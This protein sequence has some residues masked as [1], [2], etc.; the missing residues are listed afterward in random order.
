M[1]VKIISYEKCNLAI[2]V[3]KKYCIINPGQMDLES[4]RKRIRELS[5]IIDKHNY[6]YYVLAE[7]TIS[8][9]EYDMLMEEL[10]ELENKFSELIDIN[11]P[12]QRVGGMVTKDFPAVRHKY[13]MLSLGN[14]YSK[15]ELQDF[16]SRIRKAIGDAFEY[17]CE[18]KYDG[19]AI[20]LVYENKNLVRAVTRGDGY[21][22]D[23]VTT[24]ARTI[25][26]IPLKLFDGA[27][28][29]NELE[30]RGEIFMPHGSF[31]QLNEARL[32]NNEAPFANPRNAAAGSLKLRESK[33]VASRN[34]DCFIYNILGENL[35]FDDHYDNLKLAKKWGFKIPEF[36]KKCDD[37]DKVF[38][39][40]SYWEK[41]RKTLDYDT[42][43]IVIKI[44]SIEQ[45]EKLGYTAKSPRWAIAYKFPAQQAYTRLLDVK[46]QVGRTGAITPV[47][48]LQ[49][50]QLSG[51]TVKRASLYNADKIKELELHLNDTVIVEKGGEIIPKI[52]GVDI[53]HRDTNAQPVTY[54]TKCSEC[55]TPLVKGEGEA[56]HYCPNQK[57]CPPQV[58]GKIEHF[59]S[60][61]AMNI[62][63][64]GQGRTEILIKNGLVKNI[65]DLY[66]LKYEQL[67]GLEKTIVNELEGT[68]KKISFREK[69]VNNILNALEKS[70]S[71]PFERV[72]YALG[73]RYVG[74]TVAKKI[75]QHFTSIDNLMN[76]SFEQL[77]E[78]PEVGKKIAYSIILFFQDK[79]NL[80]IIDRL[81]SKG[82]QFETGEK[83]KKGGL[84][85]GKVFVISGVFEKYSRQGLKSLI[86]DNGGKVTG[87]VSS[88]TDYLVAG[89]NMG[90]E[91]RKKAVELK[92]PLINESE[93]EEL[94][95]NV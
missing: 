65:A 79:D 43:G 49:P 56:L 69:T 19:V 71:V 95:S 3:S 37:L 82:L 66:D 61:K 22:G 5:G 93:F 51:T 77:L 47:A 39:Y 12:T 16:D 70:K 86:E 13:P 76:S 73:I 60:R 10:I 67:Y 87:S 92:V 32:K 7:P 48:V 80:N 8:D 89:E 1:V 31:L 88:N 84:L 41:E 6:K 52:V 34:L 46:Y 38:Q 54:A 58:L 26:S 64:L 20:G 90:P 30:V 4:A 44:N 42:D 21:Q 35:P 72:L 25:K 74:E 23:D 91:K 27:K 2:I 40:I 81:K 85:N 68:S 57:D 28:V 15:K 55:N 53:K 29:P 78:V 59:I 17:V 14:T 75:A 18:L 50:V 45:Q 63:S 83:S 24:N 36:I 94:L 33:I 11:S 62:E 9:Y